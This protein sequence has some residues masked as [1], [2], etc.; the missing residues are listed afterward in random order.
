MLFHPSEIPDEAVEALRP[1][2]EHS[3]KLLGTPE[4]WIQ[5]CKDDTAQLWRSENGKYWAVTEIFEE[6]VYGKLFHAIASA[7][8]FCPDLIKEGEAWAK[9]QGCKSAMTGGRRGWE[10]IFT[11]N[12]YKTISVTLMKEL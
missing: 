11:A 5:R 8:E 12:G 7:G 1:A 10:K 4:Q 3:S 2:Y 9:E 6:S